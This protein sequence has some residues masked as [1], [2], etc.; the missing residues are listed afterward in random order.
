MKKVLMFSY[1]II[2][3]LIGFASLLLWIISVSNLVPE[4]SIDQ[5]PTIPFH[6]ALLKNFG[7]VSLFGLQHSIMARQSFKNTFAKFFPKPI[8]RSTFVLISG[9]LLV[10]LVLEWEPI[11]GEI[12]QVH[13]GTIFYYIIYALFFLGW[14]ILFISTFLINHFDLFGLRQT[15]LE[16]QNK[17]YTL[18]NFKVV[19]FYKHVRHPL[20][21]GGILGLWATPNMTA[22][23]F[24]FA[25]GLTAYFIIGTLFE[26][27]DLKKEFGKTYVDYQSKTRMLI[28]F[29][30]RVKR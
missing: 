4:T 14:I 23:H 12:W 5:P 18:L 8:E 21:F 13:S 9:L 28:P 7:L 6:L 27:R 16:L 1:S 15:Y 10:L 25:I 26:E 3:Y 24:V 29:P 19:S 11:G 30:K 20:Y 2:A 22:T 17:P